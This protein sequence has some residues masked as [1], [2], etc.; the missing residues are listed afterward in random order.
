M[1][2]LDLLKEMV[3]HHAS[4]LHITT[5]IPPQFRVGG[6]LRVIGDKKSLSSQQTKELSYSILTEKQIEEF[7][8]TKELDFSYGIPGLSRFRINAYMQRNCVAMSI[9][10]VPFKIP[11]FSALA[12]PET[13][14]DFS[15][16]HSGLFLVTGAV[17]SGKSTTL[18]AMIDYINDHRSCHIVT[19]ED[20]IEYLH[21]HKK[22]TI[23]QREIGTDTY[24]FAEALRRVLRQDPNIVMIGEMR[25]LET[26]HAALSL[27]ETGHLILATLHTMDATHTVSRIVD[28]FPP[29]QQQ[30]IRIQLSMVLIGV[31][32]QQLVPKIGGGRALAYEFMS[33][34]PPIQSI[35]RENN[36]PQIYSCIQTGKK[37]GMSTM[38]QSLAE[39][40]ASN[41]ISTDEAYRRSV[42]TEELKSLIE[43]QKNT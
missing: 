26:I 3:E 8:R 6:V 23:D 1:E 20:P 37:H 41:V 43:A 16:K 7:E 31:I 14:K 39:L 10:L 12:L 30:Q 28:V 9:R 35:I 11:D 27:A 25:D 33:V 29:Y 21:K 18:A 17:G 15:L 32:S 34:T 19:I 36:L 4:D 2:M 13:L 38:N 42:N 5:G 22:S 24:S 40:C